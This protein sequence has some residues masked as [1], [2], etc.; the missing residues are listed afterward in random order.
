MNNLIFDIA[1]VPNFD[2]R[3]DLPSIS[4]IKPRSPEEVLHLNSTEEIAEYIE[5]TG[6]HTLIDE[7]EWFAEL[8]R[9][10]EKHEPDDARDAIMYSISGAYDDYEDWVRRHSRVPELSTVVGIAVSP[11]GKDVSGAVIDGDVTEKKLLK[12]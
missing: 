4:S 9:L 7:P 12:R 2:I 1:A 11:D 8:T 3:Y 6:V 10:V 5:R